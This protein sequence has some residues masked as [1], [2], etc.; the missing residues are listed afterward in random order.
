VPELLR[1][2]ARLNLGGPARHVLRIDEPLRRR[3]WHGVVV[4][5]QV[6]PGEIDLTDELLDA[7]VEVV[8]L[9]D[10]GRALA[11]VA[12]RRALTSLAALIAQRR[13][14][15]VHTH[16]AKAGVLGRLAAARG[17]PRPR[18]VHTFHGHVLGPPFGPVAARA[19]A[20]V[21]RRLARRTDR[22][23]AVA[24][25]I[26]DELLQ[27]W[28]IGRA[29]QWAVVPPGIDFERV[30]PDPTAG[31]AWRA[32]LGVGP[33]DVLV[34]YVGRLDAVKDVDALLDAWPAAGP[35]GRLVVMGAGPDRERL[36]ARMHG[37]DDARIL[38][39]RR[40]LGAVFAGLDLLVLPSRAEGLPQVLVEALAAGVPVLATSVGG[41]PG[42]VRHGQDGWLVPAGDTRALAAALVRLVGDDA[43]RR[44]MARAAAA[45]DFGA[46][47]AESVAG[48]LA[49]VYDA[50]VPAATSGPV[51]SA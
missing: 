30:R 45:R 33:D 47:T 26:R 50:L 20:L 48:Q 17:R 41:V 43:A 27:R 49:E 22:L 18:L 46:M 16:T 14:A 34:G 28:R 31:R 51:P 42:L 35:R 36:A 15:L 29:P 7:G 3:G 9:P 37:R 44:A 39:P 4:T 13:P 24:P 6:A 2:I 21:E 12:D 32:E 5:G 23:I 25:E 19:F 8:R 1:V 38:P 11:P 40:E 10:L